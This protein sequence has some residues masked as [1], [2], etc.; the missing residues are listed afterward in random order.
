MKQP[1]AMPWPITR[2]DDPALIRAWIQQGGDVCAVDMY[3][4][5]IGHYAAQA[6]HVQCLATWMSIGGD[7]HATDV[8]RKTIGHVAARKGS[9]ACLSPWM[10][11]G[12]DIHAVDEDHW[13][14]GQHAAVHGRHIACLRS[15]I[16]HGGNIHEGSTI[17]D[18]VIAHMRHMV[19]S[20]ETDHPCIL[21]TQASLALMATGS[22]PASSPDAY[23]DPQGLALAERMVTTFTD[24]VHLAV[25]IQAL[26]RDQA[27]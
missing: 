1:Q 6:G 12:G 8:F 18:A 14:I 16:E 17:D 22:L 23:R 3:H 27:S 20:M 2:H 26:S 4:R 19:Q 24:P 10:A 9:D 25:W 5:T 13:T 11:A 15:W 21:V 7:I